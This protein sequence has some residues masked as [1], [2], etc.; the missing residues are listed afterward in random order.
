MHAK[1]SGRIHYTVLQVLN[2]SF[3]GITNFPLE[4]SCE[5]DNMIK[6][7]DIDE[8]LKE[9]LVKFTMKKIKTREM[10]KALESLFMNKILLVSKKTFN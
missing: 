9:S 2:F 6:V 7:S 3:T 8:T 10:Q 4:T 1:S 5:L